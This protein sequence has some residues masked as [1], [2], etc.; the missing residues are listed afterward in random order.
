MAGLG[1]AAMIRGIQKT[2]VVATIK[3]FV[4]NDQEHERGLYDAVITERALREIYLRPFQ[5]AL[6][7]GGK[8]GPGAV[9][10]A[11]NKLNGRHVSEHKILSEV[12]RGEWGWEGLVMS[13]WYVRV[14]RSTAAY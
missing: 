5:I 11:Y 7:E 2:G 3:H 9:M 14:I 4:C 1:A 10:T 6:K 8:G 13:D 12:L